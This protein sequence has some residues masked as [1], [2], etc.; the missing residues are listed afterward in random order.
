MAWRAGA[1]GDG[2]AEG[3]DIDGDLVARSGGDSLQHGLK[4]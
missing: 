4:P 2:G 3:V 1:R